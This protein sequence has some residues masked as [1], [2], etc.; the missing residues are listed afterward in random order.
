MAAALH[1]KLAKANERMIDRLVDRVLAGPHVPGEAGAQ[2]TDREV[3]DGL[4]MGAPPDPGGTAPARL[5]MLATAL[6]QTVDT[7]IGDRDR[8]S[9]AHIYGRL[10][11]IDRPISPKLAATLGLVDRAV[12]KDGALSRSHDTG[13]TYP[14]FSIPFASPTGEL[15]RETLIRHILVL[16]DDAT[17]AAR[18]C[19]VP[20]VAALA[21]A[22]DGEV[23]PVLVL[24]PAEELT[25][26]LHNVASDRLQVLKPDRMALDLMAGAPSLPQAL[27]AGRWTAYAAPTL[28]VPGII[29]V[30][31]SPSSRRSRL[32]SSRRSH[33][34]RL[35]SSAPAAHLWDAIR[36]ST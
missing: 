33:A 3:L 36:P 27:D 9:L 14:S 35:P 7:A 2:A 32:A 16:G 29:C 8:K 25:G 17:A 31:F 13:T 21:R 20:L 22:P 26:S 28:R 10:F 11:Q 6:G 4:C 5:Q 24:D 18:H 19:L 30:A 23:G 15:A 12:A 1:D 34:R